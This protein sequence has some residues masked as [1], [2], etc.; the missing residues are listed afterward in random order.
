M[1]YKSNTEVGASNADCTRCNWNRR[2]SMQ[3]P[4]YKLS[5]AWSFVEKKKIGVEETSEKARKKVGDQMENWFYFLPT[6]EVTTMWKSV[7]LLR[8]DVIWF[9]LS[10][11]VSIIQSFDQYLT[12]HSIDQLLIAVVCYM[13]IKLVPN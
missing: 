11:R 10:N 6:N 5:F 7:F 2:H 1:N 3:C 9:D 12:A 13:F 8:N 4:W